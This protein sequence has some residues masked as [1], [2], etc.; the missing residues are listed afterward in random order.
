MH[1][2]LGGMVPCELGKG[3]ELSIGAPVANA[4][5][6]LR[7]GLR[8]GFLE[9][10]EPTFGQQWAGQRIRFRLRDRHS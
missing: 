1:L 2:S 3:D 8:G 5:P 10:V 9:Q 7:T 6:M 4:M